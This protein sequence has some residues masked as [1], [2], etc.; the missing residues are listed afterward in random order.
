MKKTANVSHLVI[1][2]AAADRLIWLEVVRDKEKLDLLGAGIEPYPT[3][4]PEDENAPVSD[5]DRLR[6]AI[7]RVSERLHIGWLTNHEII[8]IGPDNRLTA[9]YLETPP[10]ADD[11]IDEL[12]S[13]EVA[14]TLQV[15]V[16]EIAWDSLISSAHGESAEKRLLWVAARKE[17]IHRLLEAWPPGTL[18]PDRVSTS[19]WGLYEFLLEREPSRLL[20][21]GLIVVKSN[22]NATILIAD[23]RAVYLMRSV[24]LTRSHDA[25]LCAEE[26][27]RALAQEIRRTISFAGDKISTDHPYHIMLCGFED[28]SLES[29]SGV[30]GNENAVLCRVSHQDASPLFGGKTGDLSGEHLPLLCSAYSI[31]GRDLPCLDLL[32][33]D[34]SR[35]V[36]GA[37]LLEQLQPARWFVTSAAAM[38]G[39][40][41]ILWIGGAIWHRHAVAE[42]LQAGEELIQ[43]VERLQR[44]QRALEELI[45]TDIDI[46]DLFILL[47]EVL[48]DRVLV[49]NINIDEQRGITFS[50]SNANNQQALDIIE[51]LN[52]SPMFREVVTDRVTVEQRGMVI[53]LKGQLQ[54]GRSGRS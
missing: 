16:E 5:E 12:V 43:V 41:L 48:P 1:L 45:R 40:I 39:F 50:I 6:A 38:L 32:P 23:Q 19:F 22:G 27:L 10:A 53:Y 17:Y 54:P 30:L 44:E 47:S 33:E 36:W 37:N 31:L 9:R 46:G 51:R 15:D 21:P 26:M 34:E 49:G 35:P 24:R 18:S 8:L 4:D 42:R 7:S 3:T 11:E 2:Q 14:E 20:R 25:D 29:L 13:F 52:N 28:L